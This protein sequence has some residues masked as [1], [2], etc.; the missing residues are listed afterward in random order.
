M[1]AADADADGVEGA[2]P[3]RPYAEYALLIGLY[4][5][6]YGLFFLLYRRKSERLETVTPLD[7]TML[8]LA[9]LRISKAISEDEITA[10][11]RRP[12]IEGEAGQKQPR[13]G[14]LRFALGEL[15]LCQTCTGTWVAAFLA[16]GLHLFPTFTRPLLAI[17]SASGLEQFSDAL[18]SLVYED[19]NV[20]RQRGARRER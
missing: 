2:A 3:P 13:G 20:L 6:L 5:A 19:R 9:T 10:G 8:S 7:L 4:Q 11:L 17:M 18:L 1:S 14:G 15:V 16:Y 12:L